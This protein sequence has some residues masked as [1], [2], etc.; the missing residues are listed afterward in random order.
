MTDF[1]AALHDKVLTIFRAWA[2]SRAD[3]LSACEPAG[4]ARTALEQA[5][6]AAGQGDHAGDI[7]FHVT[8]WAWDAAFLVAVHLHPEE[9]TPDELAAGLGS[10]LSH[11]PNHLAAAAHLSG[12]P[13]SDMFGVGLRID[14]DVR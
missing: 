6:L 1:H 10:V 12:R 9:F 3:R 8:D 4:D 5:L 13:V 2:G 11:A 14:D 7:A